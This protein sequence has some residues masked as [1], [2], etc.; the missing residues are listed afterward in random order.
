[1]KLQGLQ[2]YFLENF[3]CNFTYYESE[4]FS[5]SSLLHIFESEKLG[6][7]FSTKKSLLWVVKCEKLKL[8]KIAGNVLD[9]LEKLYMNG[10]SSTVFYPSSTNRK[11]K[12][13]FASP[14]RYFREN[15]RWVPLITG[16]NP[17]FYSTYL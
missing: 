4:N 2:Y 9:Q 6:F 11:F 7:L 5:D 1:M 14:N 3:R 16:S 17:S 8:Q 13:I 12:V 15:S 10:T